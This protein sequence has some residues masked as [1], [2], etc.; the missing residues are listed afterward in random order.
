MMAITHVLLDSTLILLQHCSRRFYLS[1][2]SQLICKSQGVSKS[3]EEE[4]L[5]RHDLIQVPHYILLPGKNLGISQA[6][7]QT[8]SSPWNRFL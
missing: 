6:M 1:H 2:F 4:S 8:P 3:T 7:Q 5:R